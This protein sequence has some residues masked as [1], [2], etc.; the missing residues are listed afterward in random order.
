MPRCLSENVFFVDSI[1]SK[2]S[3]FGWS[4]AHNL[5]IYTLHSLRYR[6]RRRVWTVSLALETAEDPTEVHRSTYRWFIWQ[7]EQCSGFGGRE[8]T[9]RVVAS[10]QRP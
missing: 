7:K 6:H 9:W 1:L 5:D 3:S 8:G 10:S 4:S 2:Q